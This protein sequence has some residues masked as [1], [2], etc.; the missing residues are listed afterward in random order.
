MILLDTNVVSE[1]L[2]PQPDNRVAE[3]LDKQ[4]VE[5]LYLSAITV[6][7]LRLGVAQLPNGRKK[8]RLHEQLEQVVLPLFAKRILPFDDATAR[9][10]ATIRADARSKG[11]AIAAADGYIVAMAQQYGFIVATRDVAPFLAA[12]LKVINPWDAD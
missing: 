7:E 2:R 11:K 1:P 10:Y 4:L 12:G 5:T 9:C 3:W 8:E 6:A